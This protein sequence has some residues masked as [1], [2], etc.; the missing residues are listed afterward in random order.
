VR[1]SALA[2]SH[3]AG[4]PTVVV[5][6]IAAVGLL[7]VLLALWRDSPLEQPGPALPTW[8][9]LPSRGDLA[10]LDWPLRVP[11]YDPA[12]V[13]QTF[14]LLADAYAD[15]LAEADPAAVARAARRAAARMEAL[16]EAAAASA[17]AGRADRQGSTEAAARPGAQA[18]VDALVAGS[19]VLGTPEGIA[20][21]DPTQEALQAEA[22]LAILRRDTGRR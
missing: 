12:T 15:L 14:D 16:H 7:V 10:R 18:E 13:E 2:A 21:A 22:V 5:S 6:L 8:D 9:G 3:T 19:A 1:I 4:V 11:G 17:P 20:P